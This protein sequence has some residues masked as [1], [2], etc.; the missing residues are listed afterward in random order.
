MTR[1]MGPSAVGRPLDILTLA[2][3]ECYFVIAAEASRPTPTQGSQL[4]FVYEIQRIYI[5]RCRCCCLQLN[6]TWALTWLRLE[7]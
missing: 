4:R 6:W 5:G 2:Q 3:R 7:C 1:P